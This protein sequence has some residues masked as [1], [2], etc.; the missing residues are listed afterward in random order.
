VSASRAPAVVRVRRVVEA[1]LHFSLSEQ[2][3]V[4]TRPTRLTSPGVHVLTQLRETTVVEKPSRLT[5]VTSFCKLQ[6]TVYCYLFSINHF[7]SSFYVTKLITVFTC[8]A[9]LF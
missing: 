1:E 6:I 9:Y 8:P 2:Q 7:I 5:L 3:Y 4:D